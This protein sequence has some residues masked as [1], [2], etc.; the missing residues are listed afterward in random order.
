MVQLRIEELLDQRGRSAYWLAKET[1]IGYP[2][3]WKLLNGRMQAF[4]FDYIDKI[5]AA[6]DCVPGDLIVLSNG[7]KK[8]GR[9]S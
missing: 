1:G 4:R 6:L 9:R 3:I 5:C 7:R 8:G 2:V